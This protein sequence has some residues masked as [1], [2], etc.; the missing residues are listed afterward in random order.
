MADEENRTPYTA[1]KTVFHEPNRL[2]IVSHLCG[3]DDGLTFGEL[4]ELCNLT[5]GNLSRHLKTL[6]AAGMVEIQKSFVGVKPRTH[7]QLREQGL[8]AFL[9]YLTALETAVR[10]AVNS[11]ARPAP[12]EAEAP[13]KISP[14]TAQA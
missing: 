11:M 4:K 6:E 2:A 9:D 13:W 7:V 5:D 1:L 8:Q 14:G 3:S 12:E 10:T